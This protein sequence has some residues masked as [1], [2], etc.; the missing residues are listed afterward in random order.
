MNTKMTRNGYFDREEDIS[1]TKARG[2]LT[3]FPELLS[4]QHRAI[5]LTRR[6]KPVMALLPWDLY[7]AIVDT[8]EI[9]ED[10]DL[11]AALRQSIK[12][13]SEGKVIPWEE[14]QAELGL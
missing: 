7:E 2:M 5:A 1:I 9:M 13:A 6:G 12:E 8:L 10:A 11:M 3:K 14:V 4:E